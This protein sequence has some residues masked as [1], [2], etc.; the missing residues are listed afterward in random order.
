ML[1]PDEWYDEFKQQNKR[2]P[3]AEEA[4]QAGYVVVTVGTIGYLGSFKLES[5]LKEHCSYRYRIS[6]MEHYVA[7]EHA[8]DAISY[9]LTDKE[10]WNV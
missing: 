3:T 10:S 4:T 5:W 8:S 2:V 9:K 1:S 6:Y 7:F